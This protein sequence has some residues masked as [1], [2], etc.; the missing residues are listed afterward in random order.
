MTFRWSIHVIASWSHPNPAFPD[1][2]F[3]RIHGLLSR[4]RVA[5]GATGEGLGGLV[6]ALGTL[7]STSCLFGFSA[8]IGLSSYPTGSYTF[9]L[10][11]HHL[12]HIYHLPLELKIGKGRKPFYSWAAWYKSGS[13]C[14]FDLWILGDLKMEASSIIVPH[15]PEQLALLSRACQNSY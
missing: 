15:E 2:V 6:Q 12:L 4:T 9:L 10:T 7:H 5:S 3:K 13:A 14:H 8:S 11:P 1:A